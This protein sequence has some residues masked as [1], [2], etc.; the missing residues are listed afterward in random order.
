MPGFFLSLYSSGAISFCARFRAN[1]VRRVVKVGIYPSMSP[2]TA[3]IEAARILSA[4][5]YGQ[6][7]S[8]KRKAGREVAEGR[9]ASLTFKEWAAEYL[10]DVGRR[11]LK[12]AS[13][14]ERY[15]ALATEA[16]GQKPL[17]EISV[18]DAEALRNKIAMRGAAS[19]NRWH[20]AVAACF[21]SARRVG[22][23]PTS[24]FTFHRLPPAQPRSRVLSADE[25]ARLRRVLATWPDTFA[26]T[27][28][29]TMLD[30]GCRVGEILRARHEDFTIDA[31]GRGLWKLPMTKSG[32]AQVI[33]L[34]A[35]VGRVIAATP[36]TDD[37]PFL[38]P[39]RASGRRYSMRQ[40]WADL[41]AAAKLGD[42]LHVHDI[43]RS[44]GLRGALSVGILG[45]SRLLR[46]SAVAVTESTYSPMTGAHLTAFAEATEAARKAKTKGKA[47]I[48]PFKK[49]ASQLLLIRHSARRPRRVFSLL[50]PNL[51]IV[52]SGGEHTRPGQLSRDPEGNQSGWC[53]ALRFRRA[54]T[55]P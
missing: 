13:E 45:A 8:E 25:E 15:I 6:D 24:P 31:K 4:A 5:S 40:A 36:K 17:E 1:G 39:G 10:K 44:F 7:E 49:S 50:L 43:R 21:N 19:A 30:T 11:R 12:S 22:H 9:R 3:R 14:I 35:S 55:S 28:F 16:W 41:K 27:A 52:P 32:K 53:K 37:S 42:D 18:A 38:I 34:I 54:P 29:L 48:L 51:F 23:I 47:K 33:P 26:R 2:E 20:V 46:H